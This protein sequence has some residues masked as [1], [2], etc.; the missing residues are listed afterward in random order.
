MAV[1]GMQKSG[2]QLGKVLAAAMDWQLAHPKGSKD[3]CI[4]H[5]K[6][7]AGELLA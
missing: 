6:G 3:E 2:P 5:L 7:R 4:A 1:M